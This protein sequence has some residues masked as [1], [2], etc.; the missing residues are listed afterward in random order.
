MV[1]L[2]YHLGFR[3]YKRLHDG[4]DL[5]SSGFG[6]AARSQRNAKTLFLNCNHNRHLILR[7]QMQ[8]QIN[9]NPRPGLVLRYIICCLYRA[10]LMSSLEGRIAVADHC[11][12]CH[13]KSTILARCCCCSAVSRIAD[14]RKL[15]CREG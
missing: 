6:V 15:P 4:R 3:M 14:E 13:G 9:N 2:K 1:C 7:V 12:G 11:C 5:R 10:K 8:V